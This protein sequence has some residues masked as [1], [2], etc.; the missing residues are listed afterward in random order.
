MSTIKRLGEYTTG[1]NFPADDANNDFRTHNL[2]YDVANILGIVANAN[3]IEEM[4]NIPILSRKYA[5]TVGGSANAITL[6]SASPY[7]T[8]LKIR[9]YTTNLSVKFKVAT[10][11]T[12]ATTINIDSI[13]NKAITQNGVALSG[14]ELTANSYV[15]LVYNGTSFDIT[16]KIILPLS[17]LTKFSVN[18]APL[19]NGSA[20]PS[21]LSGS[22]TNTLSFIN[23]S[24]SNYLLWTYA[25][26]TS[27]TIDASPSSIDISGYSDDTYVLIYDEEL[28]DFVITTS[29]NVLEVNYKP[30]SI[31]DGQYI[32]VVNPL[33]T[34]KG[35]SGAWVQNSFI[36]L[37]E[38]TIA[39]GVLGTIITYSLNGIYDSDYTTVA[40]VSRKTINHNIGST[41]VRCELFL[42][43]ITA[44][45]GFSVG[46]LL[47]ITTTNTYIPTVI[48]NELKF[49]K[50]LASWKFSEMPNPNAT[51]LLS[52]SAWQYSF[53]IRRSF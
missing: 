1:D 35:V 39:S 20:E 48:N 28:S 17:S 5:F 45:Q 51:G 12:G 16:D 18:Q 46:D 14:G 49:T 26:G 13:G 11:N 24:S 22:G 33:E 31:T 9:T 15:E 7:N 36:K 21:F 19:N 53:S 29:S 44:E 10:T 23:I 50:L 41:F 27:K 52:V 34:Y 3:S 4:Y 47:P 37:A 2:S 8:D 25:N 30:I 6:T 40:S 38:F 43:C 42:K 32:C